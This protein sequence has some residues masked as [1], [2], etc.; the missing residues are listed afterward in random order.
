MGRDFEWSVPVIPT[1]PHIGVINYEALTALIMCN[2]EYDNTASHSHLHKS[3]MAL[4]L[5]VRGEPSQVSFIHKKG[6]KEGKS[7][8]RSLVTGL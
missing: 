1:A 4:R 5:G 6:R 8:V 7:E 3:L 2:Y